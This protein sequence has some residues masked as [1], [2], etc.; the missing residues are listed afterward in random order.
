VFGEDREC[1]GKMR[2]A[3]QEYHAT[4]LKSTRIKPNVRAARA[5]DAARHGQIGAAKWAC[6]GLEHTRLV[7]VGWATAVLDPPA[8]VPLG[9]DR[10]HNDLGIREHRL[11][12]VFASEL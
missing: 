6:L 12:L 5:A 10:S 9:R 4:F 8:G 11:C 2:C 7:S 3:L 1:V